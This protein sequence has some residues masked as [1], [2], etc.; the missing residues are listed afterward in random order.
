MGDKDGAEDVACLA[1]LYTASEHTNLYSS[2]INQLS[3]FDYYYHYSSRELIALY[4]AFAHTHIYL[5]NYMYVYV[6]VCVVRKP[7]SFEGW[8]KW[9]KMH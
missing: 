2:H 7:T 8:Q 6:F 4:Y 5:A 3:Y 1:T 9:W